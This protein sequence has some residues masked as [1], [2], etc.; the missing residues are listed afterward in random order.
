MHLF[1]YEGCMKKYLLIAA[2]AVT[3]SVCVM[4]GYLLAQGIPVM[5]QESSIRNPSEAQVQESIVKKTEVSSGQ[6]IVEQKTNA[7]QQE[8]KETASTSLCSGSVTTQVVNGVAT[9]FLEGKYV[10][11]QN[12]KNDFAEIYEVGESVEAR[13]E[14]KA[15]CVALISLTS[16]GKGGAIY[17]RGTDALL[18]VDLSKGT[19]WYLPPTAGV[20]SARD[21]SPNGTRVAGIYMN[22]SGVYQIAILD[23]KTGKVIEEHVLDSAY[24]EIGMPVWSFDGKKI[25]FAVAYKWD[26]QKT[27]VIIFDFSAKS[28]NVFNTS[29]ERILTVDS[30][31]GEFPFVI[32]N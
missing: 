32:E 26:E 16:T 14:D 10:A 6:K 27:E 23:A 31:T 29:T 20:I 12:I 17:Y 11:S 3:V 13:L 18:G 9:V 30:W 19:S 1:R 24:D 22:T 5:N 15:G 7:L 21:I 2:G 4:G 28:I 25:A 8:K